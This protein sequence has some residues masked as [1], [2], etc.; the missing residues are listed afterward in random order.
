MFNLQASS[1][2]YNFEYKKTVKVRYEGNIQRDR[3][4]IKQKYFGGSLPTK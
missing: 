3:N 4:D 2:A 1:D